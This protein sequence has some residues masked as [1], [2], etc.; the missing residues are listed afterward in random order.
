M[1]QRHLGG[2]LTEDM[3]LSQRTYELDTATMASAT[4]DIVAGI[5]SP[6]AIDDQC[7]LVRSAHSRETDWHQAFRSIRSLTKA[8]ENKAKDAFEGED[9]VMLPPGKTVWRFSNALSWVANTCSDPERKL[10]L[11]QVAGSVLAA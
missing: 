3:E 4:R 2:R 6:K 7:N 10:E 9:T 8:E 11:Q 1:K 5:L